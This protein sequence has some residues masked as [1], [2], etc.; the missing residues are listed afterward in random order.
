MHSQNCAVRASVFLHKH[1]LPLNGLSQTFT[2]ESFMKVYRKNLTFTK[3]DKNYEYFPWRPKYISENIS[4]T[5]YNKKCFK[6]KLYRKL[7]YTFYVEWI[8]LKILPFMRQCRKIWFSQTG[9][10]LQY[11]K[12][13][14]LFVQD[15][16]VYRHAHS[17][18]A[19]LKLFYHCN[20]GYAKASQNSFISKLPVFLVTVLRVVRTFYSLTYKYN[21]KFH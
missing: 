11:N 6:H 17:L 7:K 8:F 12:A 13:H 9:H 4:L 3:S 14:V 1:L 20:N 10:K 18:H 15:K 21:W 2:F 19:I 5:T 16:Q